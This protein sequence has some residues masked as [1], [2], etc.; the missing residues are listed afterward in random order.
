MAR[1]RKN[2]PESEV[3][4]LAA[5]NCSVEEIAHFFSV[6]PRTIQ[7]RFAVALK[8]GRST[9]KMSLKRRMW[10]TAMSNN[11]GAVTMQIW[12][13]KQMLGYADKVDQNVEAE[14]NVHVTYDTEFAGS[15]QAQDV[16]AVQ[17]SSSSTAVPSIN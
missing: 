2:I 12:L 6:D 8:K 14:S 5:I 1:P 11:K 13:S 3:E 10:E 7:R 9:G 17:T 16:E 15:T 4:K